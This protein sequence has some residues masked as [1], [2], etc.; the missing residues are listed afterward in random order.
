MKVKAYY[1]LSCLESILKN[2]TLC[3]FKFKSYKAEQLSASL[4]PFPSPW[5]QQVLVSYVKLV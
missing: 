2:Y 1:T 3:D 5:K 4:L